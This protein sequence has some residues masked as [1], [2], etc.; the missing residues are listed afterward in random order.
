MCAT[1]A[2]LSDSSV[3]SVS[4]RFL[5][6]ARSAAGD[7]QRLGLVATEHAALYNGF[8]RRW[9][10]PR[11]HEP[12]EAEFAFYRLAELLAAAEMP[13]NVFS[14]H[15]TDTGKF[16]PI[17]GCMP[18]CGMRLLDSGSKYTTKMRSDFEVPVGR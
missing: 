8:Q 1:R 5:R 16:A 3:V 15:K 6:W 13:C 11:A 18:G 4:P 17:F 9:R 2:S 10:H 12:N 14:N 7:D